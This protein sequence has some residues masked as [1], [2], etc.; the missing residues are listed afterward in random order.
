MRSRGII[1]EVF[2]V[3]ITILAS[4]TI[5]HRESRSVKP[6]YLVRC[7]RIKKAREEGRGRK[8]EEPRA[9]RGHVWGYR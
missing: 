7:Y 8:V 3:G 1:V 6:V 9:G 5:H 2:V 4:H